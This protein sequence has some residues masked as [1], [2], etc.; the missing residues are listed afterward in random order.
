MLLLP[1]RIPA[2]KQEVSTLSTITNVGDDT[3]RLGVIA[4]MMERGYRTNI[5]VA[6]GTAAMDVFYRTER[7]RYDKFK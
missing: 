3:A 4:G 7:V 5:V 1:A 2:L 6:F